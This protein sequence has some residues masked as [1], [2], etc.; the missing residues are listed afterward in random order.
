MKQIGQID[1]DQ[2]LLS[3]DPSVLSA[4]LRLILSGKFGLDSF[5]AKQE[6][7]ISCIAN[8]NDTLVI[9]PT[10]GGKSLCYQL[11]ALALQGT[12]LVISP[13]IALMKDQVDKL[14]AL[15]IGAKALNSSQSFDETREAIRDITNGNIKLLYVSPE[16]LESEYFQKLC[17]EIQVSFIAVDEA[18]CISEWGHDFRPSYRRIPKFYELF[19][20]GRPPLIALTATATP[21]VRA[22][23]TKQL[24]LRSPNEF[25]T[26]F[27]RPNI[28]YAVITG[29]EKS[30]Q[31]ANLALS[32]GESMIIYTSSRERA[33]TIALSL[34]RVGIIAESYHAGMT[35]SD[36]HAVQE[37]F[38]SGK[39][40]IIVATSAFGMGI[41]KPD[42]RAVVHYDMPSTLEAYYQ[43]SGRAG[44]DGKDSLAI[45]LYNSG[46]ER[47]HE[48]MLGRNHPSEEDLKTLYEVLWEYGGKR[49]GEECLDALIISENEISR[50]FPAL[51]SSHS[52][53]LAI[54]EE[55]GYLTLEDSFA[56]GISATITLREPSR[57][58]EE[59]LLRIKD[60]SQK[61]IIRA[62][63]RSEAEAGESINI[64]ED[65]LL[66]SIGLS[67]SDFRKAIRSLEVKE[68]LRYYALPPSRMRAKSYHLALIGKRLDTAVLIL[69]IEHLAARFEHIAGKLKAATRYASEWRCRSQML[70]DYFGER[71]EECGNCDVCISKHRAT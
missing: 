1:A 49:I 6:E 10:G 67:R 55:A 28:R 29:S 40:R 62:L 32:I 38:L 69:P 52:R 33:D 45:L 8:G 12:A 22:D 42:V 24:A 16:R 48:F 35:S 13:L 36:R 71:A 2:G 3:S 21:E 31:V 18:H 63:A 54:L 43:E 37:K 59:Q 66:Q 17:R 53:S 44:R 51:R 5:R 11:P 27:Y 15:G 64:N 61:I 56:Q 4:K 14:N 9:M 26:S 41:D 57:Q 58:L 70:L 50:R 25:V 7:I 34:R 60:E 46:D 65:D 20:N 19:E 39:V 68:V 47:S 23:I 30:A